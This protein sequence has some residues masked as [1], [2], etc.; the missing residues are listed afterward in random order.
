M[1]KTNIF[2]PHGEKK[3]R[4]SPDPA[5]YCSCALGLTDLFTFGTTQM[6]SFLDFK[7]K[8]R[9]WVEHPRSLHCALHELA[10]RAFWKTPANSPAPFF[11]E[12]VQ[13]TPTSPR[14]QRTYVSGLGLNTKN[15]H[16]PTAISE[17][18][19]WNQDSAS[20][21]SAFSIFV[22]SCR[23]VAAIAFIERLILA[24]PGPGSVCKSPQ[25]RSII[26]E[27]IAAPGSRKTRHWV[28][29]IYESAVWTQ[30]MCEHED[31]ETMQKHTHHKHYLHHLLHESDQ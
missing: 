8:S 17:F 28:F 1:S 29:C 10:A 19:D 24:G 30:L 18:H 15:I 2:F 16:G 13:H 11:G 26:S 20:I 5:E 27:E 31:M 25:Q 22:T 3:G 4:K 21:K 7:A 12:L 6:R 9:A 23:V 14:T